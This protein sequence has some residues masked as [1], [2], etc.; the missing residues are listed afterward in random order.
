ML[1][2][3]KHVDYLD[4]LDEFD[5]NH[6]INEWVQNCHVCCLKFIKRKYINDTFARTQWQY[7]YILIVLLVIDALF[8]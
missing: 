5:N 2:K 7:I 6:V 8:L 1:W 4:S 3:H